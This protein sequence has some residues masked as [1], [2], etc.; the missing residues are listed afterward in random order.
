MNADGT[1]QMRLTTNT[2]VDENPV[3]SPI[4]VRATDTAAPV[5]VSAST[6]QS[7][8]SDIF[9][10]EGQQLDLVFSETL[11]GATSEVNLEAALLFAAGATDG[12]NLPTI[13]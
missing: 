6:P 8:G 13:G 11:S 1:S 10:L 4:G 5:L 2:A 12:D 3:W 7:M 9:Q